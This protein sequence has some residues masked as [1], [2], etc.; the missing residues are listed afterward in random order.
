MDMKYLIAII[1]SMLTLSSVIG[2]GAH[3]RGERSPEKMIAHLQSKLNLTDHQVTEITN[4]IESHKEVEGKGSRKELRT[5][6]ESVLDEEQKILFEELSSHRKWGKSEKGKRFLGSGK[7]NMDEESLAKLKEMRQSFEAEISDNDKR[8]IA[9]LRLKKSHKRDEVKLKKDSFKEMTKEEKKSL[10]ESMK[11]ERKKIKE[12]FA[13]MK[14]LVE[15]YHDQIRNLFESN[16]SFFESKRIERRNENTMDSNDNKKM[17]KAYGKGKRIFHKDKAA[18]FLLLDP[19]ENQVEKIGSI[20]S[21][22]TF[23]N[24]AKGQA[25]ISYTVENPATILIELRNESGHVL[26]VISNE[27]HNSGKFTKDFSLDSLPNQTYLISISD[28][29]NIHSEKLIK[30]E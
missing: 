27:F 6:I 17:R 19:S 16:Q 8:I 18:F 29:V 3:Q 9:D 15:K 7:K 11:V 22:S 4:L 14:P 24:P 10:K 23:P 30:Q 13:E 25:T 1:I 5:S 21:F 26:Q 2:Q 12:D 20:Q 28:G